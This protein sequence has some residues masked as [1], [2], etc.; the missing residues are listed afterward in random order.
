MTRE[1]CSIQRK[2]HHNV[3]LYT[4]N[5]I[6]TGRPSNMELLCWRPATICLPE[7]NNW[8]LEPN[9]MQYVCSLGV[10]RQDRVSLFVCQPQPQVY[11]FPDPVLT[12]NPGKLYKVETFSVVHTQ[13]HRKVCAE[14][15][16]EP[17][18][19]RVFV[20]QRGW[21]LCSPG[22]AAWIVDTYLSSCFQRD[23]TDRQTDIDKN[24]R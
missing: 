15:R 1:N 6:R 7:S 17:F 9:K 14:C 24:V 16:V 3:T 18:V 8:R 12:I 4:T 20:S 23:K 22:T 5:P 2:P 13:S 19:W 11:K 10:Q 21:A